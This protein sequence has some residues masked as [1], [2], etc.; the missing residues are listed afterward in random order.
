MV[1]KTVLYWPYCSTILWCRRQYCI[2]H[3]IQRLLYRRQNAVRHQTSLSPPRA[4]HGPFQPWLLSVCTAH[5]STGPCL[6]AR[7]IP[8]LVTVCLHGPFQPWSWSVCTAHS[9][10]S[11]GLSARPI[12]ALVIICL[13]GPFQPWSLSSRP[14]SALVIVTAHSSPGHCHGPFQPWSS[15]GCTAWTH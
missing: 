5:S 15:S 6:S 2:G 3:F 12:P 13:H 14:I 8:A 10:P 9:S 1:Q 4:M 7:P 11:H